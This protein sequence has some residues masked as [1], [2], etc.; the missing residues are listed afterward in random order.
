VNLTTVKLLAPHLTDDN[1]REVLQ[2]ACGLSRQDVE[3]IVARLAPA[4]DVPTSIQK[5]PTVGSSAAAPTADLFAAAPAL[6]NPPPS[7]PPPPVPPTPT[8]AEARPAVISALSPERY[9]LQVTISGVT[10]E[11]LERA[12]DMLRHALPSGDVAEIVDRAL[13]LLLTDLDKKKFAATA[14]PRPARGVAAHATQVTQAAPARQASAP[15]RRIVSTRDTR[16]CTY[17]SKDGRRCTERA[18]LEFHHLDPYVEGGGSTERNIVLLCQQ[19]NLYEWHLRST[20]V[21][22]LEEEWLCRQFAAGVVPWTATTGPG[23]SRGHGGWPDT[24]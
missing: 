6:G 20:A 4:P 13:T 17:V 18:L 11:K 1:H 15:V 23:T 10:L 21:R 22:E 2:S 12:K 24:R 16:Q 3:K 8:A 14:R 5:L 7:S 19:H 9:K